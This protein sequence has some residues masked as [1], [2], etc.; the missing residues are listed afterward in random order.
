MAN[1][2]QFNVARFMTPRSAKLLDECKQ[3]AGARLPAVIQQVMSKADDA[4]FDS[5][6]KAENSS[7]Q[8]T[9]FHA[10]RELRLLRLDI[11]RSFMSHFIQSYEDTID[12]LATVSGRATF[13]STQDLELALVAAQDMEED[14]AVTNVIEKIKTQCREELYALDRR[15]GSILCDPDLERIKNPL[16]PEI[17][18]HAFRA[19]CQQFETDIEVKLTLYKLLDRFLIAD[20]NRV[21]HDINQYL[22]GEGVL[23]KVKST[24]RASSPGGRT[25]ITIESDAGTATTE[26]GDVFSALQQLMVAAPGGKGVAGGALSFST[27]EPGYGSPGINRSSNAEGPSANT[28]VWN[29]SRLVAKLTDLQRGG[30]GTVDA[31]AN[32]Q[33]PELNRL[34]ALRG[35]AL[36]GALNQTDTTTLEIVAIL[37]DY[38]F[39]DRAI[40]DALKAVIGR[41]QIPVLKVALLDKELFSRKS[42]PARRLLDA[43]AEAAIG[44]SDSGAQARDALFVEVERVVDKICRD[45]GDDIAVFVSALA[46]F[47]AFADE[48]RQTAVQRA[49]RSAKSLHLKERLVLARMAVD[50]ALKPL[51][52]DP[53]VREFARQFLLDYWRQ[54]MVLTHVEQGPESEQ[55][56]HQLQTAVDL[57]GSLRE[58]STPEERRALSGSLRDLLKR[59]RA[60]MHALNM[61]PKEASKFLGMLASVHVV[62]VKHAEETRIAE[63]APKHIE[64]AEVPTGV[65]AVAADRAEVSSLGETFIKEGMKRLFERDGLATYELDIDLTFAAEDIDSQTSPPPVEKLRDPYDSMVMDLN[66]GDWIEFRGLEG[67]A[68][69]GRFTWISPD[70]GRLLF[71]TKEGVRALD[72]TLPELADGLR[73][74]R[75]KIIKAEPD[76]IFDRAISALMDKMEARAAG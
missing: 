2:P 28:T 42:H 43:L 6:E 71:T 54:L 58:M 61:P 38:F 57:L 25:R 36:V 20:M 49:D 34:H 48:A 14:L 31:N 56:R 47:Q 68:V 59:L 3:I 33:S 73:A 9:F 16:R 70:T 17:I 12:P 74:G 19:A 76:P 46:E 60:G 11:E 64:N 63:L 29:T 62:A 67:T 4:L 65:K 23:P 66:L 35:D 40:P 15:I 75:I 30:Y 10:M 53:G 41:L 24:A 72:T 69:R 32:G 8:S 21:Y 44:C 39:N 27:G 37:F 7:R 50:D 1:H 51:L 5:A 22:I 55:W 45:F 26:A 18:G 13:A 52:D